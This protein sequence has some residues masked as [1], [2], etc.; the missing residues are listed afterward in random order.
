MELSVILCTYNPRADLLAEVMQALAQQT[1]SRERFEIVV[2]DNHSSP[3]VEVAEPGMEVRVV[4]EPTPGLNHARRAGI[5]ATHADLLVFVD[6]DNILDSE[7]LQK[8]VDI[9]RDN[10]SIG[11]FGGIARGR[12][13]AGNIPQWKRRLLDKLGV[14]EIGDQVM[15]SAED[16][17]GPWEPIGAG[18]VVRK[19]VATEFVKLIETVED[20]RR[21]DRS[22]A[23][24]LMSGGDTLMARCAYRVGL[25]CSYQP[26]LKLTHVIKA[27]RLKMGY[28]LRILHGHGR[29]VVVL[30]RAL[31]VP[32][33][34]M[35]VVE[36]VLRAGYRLATRGVPG[37]I[38]YAWDWGYFLEGRVK[39]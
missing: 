22:G 1:L 14:R 36:L 10:P 3:S 4:R 30:N 13:E 5:L 23:S 24:G 33:R 16:R 9:A 31:G 17:W 8:A 15:T 18:M 11:A 20:A 29:S 27:G 25:A 21:L 26:A 39:K 2:V 19:P 32:L 34:K 6:D 38:I 28:L 37:C 12:V 7:Y 35:G